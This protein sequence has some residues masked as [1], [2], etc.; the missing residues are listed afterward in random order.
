MK[1]NMIKKYCSKFLDNYGYVGLLTEF[2]LFS[3]IT[4]FVDMFVCISIT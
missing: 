3:S 4:F 1:N 2:N